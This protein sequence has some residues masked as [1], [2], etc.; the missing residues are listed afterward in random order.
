MARR[1]TT[2]R[3]IFFPWEKSG[4]LFRRLRFDQA[5]PF[6]FVVIAA[7]LLFLVAMRERERSGVRRTHAILLNVRSAVDSYMADHD[8]GCP[9]G[10]IEALKGNDGLDDIPK[11]AWGKPLRLDCPGRDHARYD[12]TSDGPDGKRGGLDRIE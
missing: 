10:G 4:G 7:G 3:H 11:D 2:D 12:L 9:P 8:G 6:L 5:R 1:R